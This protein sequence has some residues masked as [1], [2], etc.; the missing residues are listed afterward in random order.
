MDKNQKTMVMDKCVS[1]G[2]TTPYSVNEHIDYRNYYIEGAGQL[3]TKCWDKGTERTS[4]LIPTSVIKDTPNDME[5]GKLV[6]TM[7]HQTMD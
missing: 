3:C 7:Y 4:I 2:D 1:C 5:L 6:R